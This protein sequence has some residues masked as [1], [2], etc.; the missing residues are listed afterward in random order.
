MSAYSQDAV[1]HHSLTPINSTLGRIFIMVSK[2]PLALPMRELLLETKIDL[3]GVGICVLPVRISSPILKIGL[4]LGRIIFIQSDIEGI[5]RGKLSN[6]AKEGR[7][8]IAGITS[9][10]ATNLADV[11]G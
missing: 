4:Y 6:P 2:C 5:F 10:V 1:H 11:F 7:T 9:D 8:I 3:V